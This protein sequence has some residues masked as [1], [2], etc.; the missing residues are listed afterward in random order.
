MAKNTY[1]FPH[2]YNA[3]GDEKMVALQQK[4][5]WWGVGI[6]WALIEKLYESGGWYSR[7]Y[8]LLAYELRTQAERIQ[9]VVEN[10]KLFRLKDKKFTSDRV[11]ANLKT[12]KEKSEK[13]LKSANRRWK[14]DN[15]NA[16]PTHSEGNAIK[17]KKGEEI[18]GEEKKEKRT[19]AL[20]LTLELQ[21]EPIKGQYAPSLIKDFIDYWD[22]PDLKGVPRWRKEKTWEIKRRLDRWQRQ[23]EKWAYEKTAKQQLK[24][25]EEM[26]VHREYTPVRE[27]RGF[28]GIGEILGD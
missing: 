8:N 25:V 1:Y 15:A 4:M 23:Q 28:S 26:P 16:M 18:K 13:A 9:E 7:D 2:D 22:E 27:D 20:S 3:R 17:E 5:D 11:L 12:Q 24:K 6:Y 10:Y 14:D 21:I 19:A